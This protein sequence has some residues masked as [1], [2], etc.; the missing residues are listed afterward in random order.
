MNRTTSVLWFAVVILA[1]M[2][3]AAPATGALPTSTPAVGKAPADGCIPTPEPDWPQ[4]RGPRR[5][6]ISDEKGLLP[7]WPEGGP[8]L[9][10][11]VGNLGKGWSSPIIVGQT[12]YITGDV[13]DELVIYAFDL[14]GKPRWQGRNGRSWKGSYPG[15]RACCAYSQ[16][17]LYHMNA[18]GRIACLDPNTGKELWTV[19]VLERFG[20]KNIT[21]AI[22]ECLVVDGNN[23]IVTPG[24]SKA[25]MAA[26]DK[27]T[28]ETVWTTEPIAGDRT[29]YTSPILFRCAGRRILASCSS[30]HGFGVDADTG[31]LLWTFPLRNRYEVT[32]TAPAFADGRVFYVA[33]DGP[34]GAQYRLLADEKGVRLEETWKTRLDTLTGYTIVA[35]GA[36]YGSGYR[37]SKSWWRLDW[38]TGK[39]RY[40]L[41]DPIS[42]AAVYADGRLYCLAEDGWAAMLKPTAD[43]FEVAGRFRLV[44][45]RGDAWAHPVI[46]RGRMYLRY[47][48]NLWCF[49]VKAE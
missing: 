48:D 6:G 45:A 26:L 31:K 1:A 10:W 40:E 25:L 39:T 46:F 42:G 24:G 17:R 18:H 12:L 22:S 33:P 44:Q 20:G 49:Q 47:H 43:R 4:W 27:A 8:K 23:V 29:A 11:K 28:G 21:W 37:N 30:G 3:V 9:L 5:D 15:A 16:G 14:D 7:T 36:L 19:G 38:E 13:A 41:K 35:D 34:D 2:V 32:V